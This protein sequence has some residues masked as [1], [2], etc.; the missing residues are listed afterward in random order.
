MFKLLV[1]PG[2]VHPSDTSSTDAEGVKGRMH[3]SEP[4]AR[5][6]MEI[7]GAEIRDHGRLA[8]SRDVKWE[9]A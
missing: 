9:H 5:S 2:S 7:R 8:T 4:W 6:E 3:I 1:H